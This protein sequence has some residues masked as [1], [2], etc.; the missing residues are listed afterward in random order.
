MTE[1]N[2]Y[3]PDNDTLHRYLF[4]Q[5]AV[6]G[7]W[8]RL[9]RTFEE[10]LNTH[11]YPKAVQNLLG[12]MLVATSLLTATLKFEGDITVQIQGDGPL[13]LALVNGNHQLQLRALARVEGEIADDSSLQQMIGKAV[14]VIS[15]NP[16]QGERYQGIVEL[17]KATISECLQDYFERSEQ[18]KTALFIKTGEFEGKPVAAGMLLQIM[19]DGSGSVDDLEH[20][21]MLTHTVKAMELFALPAEELLYRLYHEETVELFNPS[22]VS[23][24]C[25]CSAE[26]SGAA[27]LLIDDDEIDEILHEH[28]GSID[29]QCECCGTHYFF[30]KH[31]I[32]Q[33]KQNSNCA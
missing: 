21:Q 8:V 19:P 5:K 1:F 27:L 15:I 10:T 29:M 23:F 26:R 30:N 20:L 28:N 25:G 2:A 33:L 14:L 13:K 12:E 16:K 7:E 22:A 9:N 3:Q 6:R 17:S 24:H 11:H 18:L 32:E 31:A 4:Q